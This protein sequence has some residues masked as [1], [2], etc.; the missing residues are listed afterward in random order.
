MGLAAV[1]EPDL[2]V[3]GQA[4]TLAE[5]EVFDPDVILWDF[6]ADEEVDTLD[7]PVVALIQGDITVADALGA[8]IMGLLYRDADPD[9][10]VAALRAA[11]QGLVVLEPEFVP[12]AQEARVEALDTEPLT[13]REQEVLQL[14]SQGASNKTLAKTLGISESTAKFH[15]SAILGKLGAKSRT[16]AV[17]RAAQLGLILL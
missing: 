15:T 13:A 6:N 12:S 4:A 17:V 11:L 7:A 9:K 3:V 1:L 8:E 16:E 14:L 5:A 2:E 10:I